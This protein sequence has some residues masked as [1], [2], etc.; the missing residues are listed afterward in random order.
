MYHFLRLK[1]E[2][3]K[4]IKKRAL[5]NINQNLVF[6]AVL[7]FLLVSFISGTHCVKIYNIIP[8]NAHRTISIPNTSEETIVSFVPSYEYNEG[9]SIIA[10]VNSIKKNK[11]YSAGYDLYED[12]F[13]EPE[14]M[15]KDHTSD[16]LSSS[17][18]SKIGFV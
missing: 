16:T 12:D 10:T 13:Y 9:P 18:I 8:D 7:T 6:N 2:K 3:I 1:K 15:S 5:K 14:I 4:P 11:F 17:I